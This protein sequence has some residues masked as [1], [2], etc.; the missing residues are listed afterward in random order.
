[1]VGD[2]W[3]DRSEEASFEF[4]VDLLEL[5]DVWL[6]SSGGCPVCLLQVL[7]WGLHLFLLL[8]YLDHFIELLDLFD[9]GILEQPVALSDGVSSCYLSLNQV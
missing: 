1:V 7:V 3:T 5:V 9:H 4:F 8:F 2:P 6:V